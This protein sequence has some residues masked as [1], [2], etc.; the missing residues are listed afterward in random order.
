MPFLNG[1]LLEKMSRNKNKLLKK[2]SIRKNIKRQGLLLLET[3]LR[4]QHVTNYPPGSARCVSHSQSIKPE[5]IECESELSAFV[6]DPPE[7]F[8]KEQGVP[9]EHRLP[10]ASEQDPRALCSHHT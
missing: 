2:S 4:C 5:N 8:R 10:A 7:G 3:L 9:F 6:P 1:L